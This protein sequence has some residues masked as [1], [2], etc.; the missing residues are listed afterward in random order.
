MRLQQFEPPDGY[1]L[2]FGGGKDSLV[3]MDL[4][5]KAGVRFDS[6]YHLSMDP[7]E[8]VMFVKQNYPDVLIEKSG[9]NYWNLIVEKGFPLRKRRWCCEYFK[10]HGGEG[11]GVITGVRWAESSRRKNRRMVETTFSKTRFALPQR[12]ILNPIVDWTTPDV[13]EY[14]AENR[15]SYCSLYDEGF[16]RLGCVMCPMTSGVNAQLEYRR[17]PKIAK[18]Y[19]NAFDRLYEKKKDK[20]GSRWSSGREMFFWWLD[21]GHKGV[22]ENQCSMFT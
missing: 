19:E 8:L 11:R 4:A 17:H 15:I 13:W 16:K 9:F 18:A 6:H 1:Y 20:Y 14:I 3:I 10:E 7:P 5:I 22:N 12:F 2:A 21:G